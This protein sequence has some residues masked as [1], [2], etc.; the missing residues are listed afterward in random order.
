MSESEKTQSSK[1]VSVYLSP[2]AQKVLYQ[3]VKSSGYGS[4]SRTIE[5]IITNYNNVYNT[6]MTSIVAS[7]GDSLINAEKMRMLLMLMVQ[8]FRI[9][10][11]SPLELKAFQI[12]KEKTNWP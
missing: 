3:Y 2:V 10:N 5:E 1:A 6:L 7:E 4:T 8:H 12:L 9:Q 11:G